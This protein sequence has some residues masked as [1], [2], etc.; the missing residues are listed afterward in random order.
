MEF[1][2]PADFSYF[3]IQLGNYFDIFFHIIHKKPQIFLFK[4]NHLVSPKTN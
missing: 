3:V 4:M 2:K 1:H